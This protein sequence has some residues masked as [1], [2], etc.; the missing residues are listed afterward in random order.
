M[1]RLPAAALPIAYVV[2]RLTII[3]NWVYGS[4]ILALLTF[5]FA[6]EAFFMRA[7]HLGSPAENPALVWGVRAVAALGI[8]T[9]PINLAMLKRMI[10]MVETVRAGDPFVAENAYRLQAVAWLLLLLQLVGLAISAIARAVSSPAH[11]FHVDAGFSPGGWLAVILTF[12]LARVFAEGT[13][14]REDL[15]GTV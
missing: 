1:S 7:L 3:L 5:S 2:L 9:V 12:V 14:M 15:E 6:N 11:P 13:L 8:L 10:A 4:V